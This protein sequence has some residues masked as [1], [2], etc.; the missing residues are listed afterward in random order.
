MGGLLSLL[1]KVPGIGTAMMRLSTWL[2]QRKWGQ[3]LMFYVVGS[4]GLYIQKIIAF[5]GVYLVSSEY[6]TPALL[7]LVTGPMLG[8]PEPFPEL[9]AL[10][11]IDK[12]I[13]VILSAIVVQAA[14]R[15][16]I[17]RNPQAPGWTTSPGAGG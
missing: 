12:G 5:L 7:P 17:A 15:I 10:T 6:A 13:T 1:R 9:L 2:T 14:S 3:W 16:K 8:M 4:L 11:K